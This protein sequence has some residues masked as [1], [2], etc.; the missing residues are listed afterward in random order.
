MK[1]KEETSLVEVF[2]GTMWQAG[3]IKSLLENAGIEAFLKDE[4]I[5]TMGPWWAAPG[6]AGAVKVFVSNKQTEEAQKVVDEYEKN[7]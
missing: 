4:I 2:A 6:G 7:I 5:G 1:T 3:M